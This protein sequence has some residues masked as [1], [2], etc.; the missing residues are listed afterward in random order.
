MSDRDAFLQA[1]AAQPVDRTARLVY[2]D[3]LE[4]SG[5]P[6]EVAR[7]EFIRAQVE[8]ETVHPNNNRHAELVS[9]ARE[10]FATHW[11]DW[12]ESVCDAVGLPQRPAD[13]VRGW[14]ARRFRKPPT[15]PGHPYFTTTPYPLSI[16]ITTSQPNPLDALQRVGFSGGFPESLIFLGQPRFAAAYL[17]RWATASPLAEL[18]L[19]GIVARDWRKIDGLHLCGLLRIRL[20]HVAKFGLETI[21]SF[22]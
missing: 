7:A 21:A 13:G 11:L 10:V 17:R 12:W 22:T 3:F 9:R 18:D 16:A 2:A 20:F 14:F 15:E 4:E 6:V 5:E 8:A 19:R 1:I